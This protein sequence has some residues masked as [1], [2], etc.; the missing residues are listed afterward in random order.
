LKNIKISIA[1]GN[2][3]NNR[4]SL[5][6]W[7]VCLMT[8]V[9][10]TAFSLWQTPQAQAQLVT[11]GTGTSTLSTTVGAPVYWS[12][13]T[14]TFAFHRGGAI[15]TASEIN[16][17]GVFAGSSIDKL[18]WF[19]NTAGFAG[20][21]TIMSRVYIKEV[22]ATTQFPTTTITWAT[23]IAGATLVYDNATAISGGSGWKEFDISNYIWGGGNIM[24][25]V[26]NQ[27]PTFTGSGTIP[28]WRYTSTTNAA[29]ST[30]GSTMP[31]T[32]SR[33]S[34]RINVQMEFLPATPVDLAMVN[35]AAPINPVCNGANQ[36]VS[37]T[38]Q[39]LGTSTIDFSVNNATITCSVTGPNPTSFPAVVLNSGTLAS[40]ATQVITFSTNYDMT[41]AGTY[42][43]SFNVS[44]AGDGFAG[45]DLLASPI[46]T[47]IQVDA[48]ASPF[49]TICDGET[50]QLNTNI[51]GQTVGYNI[52]S[53]TP[54]VIPVPGG[55]LSPVT[56]DDVYSG[57]QTL[58]FTFT[59]YGVPQTVLYINSNGYVEFATNLATAVESRVPTLFPT[60][61]NP[62]N[63]I[64]FGW[65]DLNPTAGQ[66]TAYTVGTAPFRIYVVNFDNVN[67]FSATPGISTQLQLHENN[68]NSRFEIHLTNNTQGSNTTAL[69][70]ENA[71]GTVGGSPPGR[72]VG[73]WGAVTY[74]EAWRF[75]A[76]SPPTF[77]WSG[78]ALS[79]TNISNPTATPPIGFT[80]YTVTVT[81]GVTGCS[82]TD[83]VGINNL[84]A[85][86]P[87]P[88]APGDSLCQGETANLTASGPGTL[89]W[90]DAPVG[91]TQL[92]TGP[93]FNPTPLVTDTFYVD[94]FNGICPSVRTEVIVVVTP[95]PVLTVS[96]DTTLCSN[97]SLTLESQGFIDACGLV[98]ISE[99]QQFEAGTGQGPP[100]PF[101]PGDDWI[102]LTNI[103][104]VPVDISGWR[105]EVTGSA[106]G[107]QV[108]PAGNI[109]P[110]GAVFVIS[111]GAGSPNI[112]GVYFASTLPTTSSTVQNGYILYD[113]NNTIKDV[114]A[115]N[116]FNVVGTGAPAV[117]ASDW[118]GAIGT[119][120]SGVSR[121][122]ATDNNNASDWVVHAAGPNASSIG[123]LNT[124]F[125][126]P[127][128]NLSYSWSTGDTTQ[129]ITFIVSGTQTYTVTVTD[130]STG[131]TTTGSVTV[132]SP[133]VANNAPGVTNDTICVG[134]TASITATGSSTIK[135]YDSE[136][137]GTLLFT[138][139]TFNPTPVV[140][141]SYWAEDD[142]GVC[143][144]VRTE[145]VVVVNPLPTIFPTA[146][147]NTICEGSSTTLHA[148]NFISGTF[149]A[150]PVGTTN[151]SAAVG[152]EIQNNSAF[153]ITINYLYFNST[154]TLGTNLTESVYLRTSSM[155]CSYPTN[156]STDANWTLIASNIACVSGGTS[157]PPSVINYTL[158]P[159]DLNVTIPPGATYSFALGGQS[160]AYLTGS[161]CATNLGSDGTIT[162]Y[163]GWGG[164]L[165]SSI[166]N[167]NFYGK[168]DYSF[169]DPNLTFDWQPAASLNNNA[170]ADPV[171][172]PTTTT[173][174]TLTVT[175]LN[176]C[177][178]SD[179][180][181]VNVIPALPT[182]T[183]DSVTNVFCGCGQANIY[184][185]PVNGGNLEWY[186]APTGGNLIGTGSPLV[187][188]YACGTQTWYAQ[189]VDPGSGC[190]SLNR[191]AVTVIPGIA[192]DVNISAS[193]TQL[194]D[195]I[196]SA[197]LSASS[198]N[199]PNYQYSWAPAA[200]L[201][202]TSGTP[203][204]AT[205]SVTTTYILTGTD[206]STGC[207]NTDTVVINVGSTPIITSVTADQSVFCEN[208]VINLS[209]SA[210]LS[211]GTPPTN[212]FTGTYVPV[213]WTEQH[214]SGDLGTINFHTSSDLNMNSSDGGTGNTSIDVIH[215]INANGFVTFDWQYS[216][217]DG[218]NFDF[219]QYYLN[220][221]RTNVPGYNT[222][223]GLVQS[224]SASIAV[225]NGDVFGFT[226]T[227][228]DNLFGAATCNFNNVVFPG[229]PSGSGTI[230]YSWSPATNPA[231]GANVQATP[232]SG[233]TYYVVTAD[234]NGCTS[235][236]SILV[237]ALPTP[238]APACLGD[239]ICG[240][241]TVN[242][243]AVGSGG[244]LLWTDTI[245][246]P[247][248][249]TGNNYSPYVFSSG[250][251]YVVEDPG[252]TPAQIGYDPVSNPTAGVGY[253]PTTQQYMVFSVLSD[254]GLRINTVDI[255]P[256][257]PIGSPYAIQLQD[258]A[259]NNLG[260]L[261][262][263]VTTVT[264]TSV[265]PPFNVQTVNLNWFVP[266]GN[267]YRMRIVTSPNLLVH[268]NGTVAAGA[269][270]QIPFQILING[271][272]SH[273]PPAAPTIFGSTTFGLFYNW[274]V[275]YGCFSQAC[276]ANYQV[277]PAPPLS[278]TP[279]GSTSACDQANVVLTAGGDPS[280]TSFSWSPAAGLSATSG[281]SVTATPTVTTTYI[282][283]A[284]GG[285]CIDTASVTITVNPAPL[286]SI[287]IPLVD[288][289]CIGNGLQ[290][291]AVASKSSV[292]TIGGG[293]DPGLV[294]GQIFNGANLTQRSQIL[295]RASE[296]NAA[297]ILGPGQISSLAFN[298][299]NKLST[300]PYTGF[301]I[302]MAHASPNGCFAV[303]TYQTAGFT[304]VFT[305]NVSTVLGWNTMN[306]STP[307][308][309]DGVS[310]VVINTCFAN[311][312]TSFFDLVFM[313]ATPAC[314]T[315]RSDNADPC[316]DLTGALQ[317]FRPS[318][319]LT[320]GAVTYSWS[321]AANLDNPNIANPTFTATTLGTENFFVTVTDPASGCTASSNV[322]VVV[323]TFPEA[324]A[325]SFV[326]DSV[327]CYSGVTSF[328]STATLGMLQWQISND[329]INFSDISGADSSF[330][331]TDTL[332]SMTWYRLKAYCQDTVYS[333]ILK[334]DISAPQ[335]LSSLGDTICG[336][337]AVNLT[338]TSN[339]FP[340]VWYDEASG[341]TPLA[342]GSPFN[343]IITGTDTFYVAAIDTLISGSGNQAGS[344]AILI[345]EADLGGTDQI[346]IQNVS[347]SA[348]DVTGWRLAVSDS[349]TDI[350]FVNATVQVLSGTIA[351]GQT[352]FWTDGVT[353]PWGSNLFWNPGSFPS[354]T[355]WAI[356]MDNTGAIRDFVIWNWPSAN[357][358][359]MSINIPGNP[360]NPVAPASA[361][362]GNG[363]DATTANA[364]LSLSRNGTS[365]NNDLNDFAIQTTSI[366]A[367]NPGMTLPF[368]GS[369]GACESGRVMV[370]AV[371]TPADDITASAIDSDLCL[372]E[373]T[374]L[375][376][377]S[378]NTNYQYTWQP[379]NLIG[380][381]VNVCPTQTTTYIVY[382]IDPT[383]PDSCQSSD[384]IT[385][386]VNALPSVT[387][388]NAVPAVVCAGDSIQLSA[389][390]TSPFG[391]TYQVSSVPF[392]PIAGVGTAVTLGDDQTSAALPIGFN[393][394][395]YGNSYSQFV[396][397]SN[398]FISFDLAAPNGCCTGGLLPGAGTPNNIIT[399]PWEDFNPGAGG[400]IDYFTTGISPNQKLVVNF[401][402]IPHFG[403]GGSPMTS[404]IV[405][406]EGSNIIQVHITQMTTDGG[407]HTLGIENSNGTLAEVVPGRNANNSWSATN[408]G[409][410]F[411]PSGVTYSWAPAGLFSNPNQQTAN[412]VLNGP[413]TF[414][415]TVTD[416]ITGC[417]AQD[418]I[419]VSPVAVPQPIISPDDTTVC[420]GGSVTL[421]AS[422]PVNYPGGWPI[423]T[424][425]DWGFGPSP[426]STFTTVGVGLFQ[427]TVYFPPNF[428]GCIATS[429][430]ANVNFI[431]APVAVAI[432]TSALCAGDP[433]GSITGLA[434]LGVPPY[435]Y[436]WYDNNNVLIRDTI[437]FLGSDLI[438]GLP[439]GNYCLVVT[440]KANTNSYPPPQCSSFPA[441]AFVGEPLPVSATE[442]HVDVV[443][444]G[445]ASG[446]IDITPS[447]GTPPYTYL[448]S[449][450][451]TSEDLVNITAGTYTVTV[452]DANGCTYQT[453][454]DILSNP[455]I[456]VGK[457][458]V[459]VSCFGGGDGIA[460]VA[461][462]GGV[463]PYTYL[464]SNGATDEDADSLSSG[465][466][467]VTITDAVGCDTVVCFLIAEPAQMQVVATVVN[468]ACH[469]T[470]NGSISLA[471]SGG[472]PYS[473]GS[474][475]NFLWSNGA[476]TSS[477]SGLCAGTYTIT[478]SDS[479]GCLH[480]V[481]AQVIQPDSLLQLQATL[482]NP[483]CFGGSNG[484]IVAI[485]Q[486]GVAPYTYLWSN[487]QTTATATGL[488]A[489]TYVVTVTDA[490]GCVK[491][492]SY[493]L[494][495][496]PA[497]T[498]TMSVVNAS[499]NGAC[500]GKLIVNISGG[501]PPYSYLWNTNPA[502]T[503]N[504]ADNLCAGSY[505]LIVTDAN[506]CTY[507][508]NGTVTEPDAIALNEVVTDLV[509]NGANNGIIELYVTGG[510]APY[511][512]IWSNGNSTATNSGLSAGSY[513]VTV[514]D[515][516]GCVH[517]QTIIV[518]EPSAI[519]IAGT[520]T[521]VSCNGGT[522]GSISVVV[523]GGVS[524]YLFD[525]N[526]G[527]TTQSVAGLPAGVYTVTVT[528]DNGCSSSMS[529]TITEPTALSCI[530]P[531]SVTNV[532]CA[533]GSDG[534]ITAIPVGGTPPYS[535]LWSNGA[536]TSTVGGLSAGNYTVT[537]TDANGCIHISVVTVTEPSPL[538]VFTIPNDVSC[539]GLSD[540]S[541]QALA[542][543]GT[544]PYSYSWSTNPVQTTSTATGLAAGAYTVV[545][546]DANGCTQAV[547]TTINE[548]AEIVINIVRKKN[549][550]CYGGS[551]GIAK[552]KAVGGTSPFS[553]LWSTGATTQDIIGMPAGTYK[554]TVT[555]A[556]GCT[557]SRNVT[558]NSAPQMV[559][560]YIVTNVSCNGG[561][562]GSIDLTVTGGTPHNQN[563]P[564][565][566]TWSNGATTEDLTGISAGVYTVAVKDRKKCIIY[567][568]IIVNEPPALNCSSSST[569]ASCSGGNDGSASVFPTGG[570]V[571][572]SFLW[573]NGS[574]AITATNLAAGTYTVVVTDAK[575]CTSECAVTV[576]QS[577]SLSC[578]V[579]N[580][581][582]QPVSCFGANDGA[583][584]IDV[585]GG[586]GPYMYIWSTNPV[587][588]TA[589]ATGLPA[590]TYTVI[591]V[592]A[593]G[594][595]TSCTVVIPEPPA[596]NLSCS[597]DN[598]VSCN[599][600]NDGQA[601]AVA[602]GG[603]GQLS[604]LWNTNPAQTTATAVGLSTGVW[605][606]VV[607]DANG[608][609]AVCDVTVTEPV[610]ITATFS[611]V[612]T[613]CNGGNDG[614]ATVFP[615]GGTGA[616]TYLWSDGQTTQT[617]SGLVAGSYSV[618]VTDANNCSIVVS[619]II[620][621]QPNS[622]VIGALS[623]T[624]VSCT[625]GNNGTASVTTISGGTPP[626]TIL[627]NTVPPQNTATATGL[628]AGMYTVTV[629]DAVGCSAQDSI[630]VTEPDSAL[631]VT[632]INVVN[633]PCNGGLGSATALAEGGTAPYSYL[634][635]NGQT[636]ATAT[637]LTAGVYVVTV[638]D[639]NGCNE[640]ANVVI[641]QPGTL[642]V[643][644]DPSV[645]PSCFGGN[646]GSALAVPVG[647]T[648]PYSYLWSDG[649]TTDL[650][651]G[652]IAGVYTVTVTDAGG[653]TATE[654]V[655]I[656]DPSQIIA[657]C[658]VLDH[659]SCNGY[660]DGK[661][662]VSAVGGTGA[663]SYL[664]SNGATT[665]TANLVAAGVHTVTITDANGCSITC[666]VT[667]NE[668]AGMLLNISG[669]NV[670]CN[671]GN[672]G[673]A[674]VSVSGG[675]APYMFLWNN[676]QNTP[677]ATNLVAG[678]YTVIVQDFSG[679]TA[680][681][682][683][684]ITEPSALVCVDSTVV[685][686]T[687]FGSADGSGTT[688][689]SGGT[690]YS[691]GAPYTYAWNTVPVQTTAT[692]TGLAAG[693]Y[694]VTV[695]D[696]LGCSIVCC[697][698]IGQPTQLNY[699]YT[700]TNVDCNG[701]LT[702][703]I[704]LTVSG[705]VPSYS[706]VWSNGATTEDLSGVGA[707]T[708]SVT[709]SDV[710]GCVVNAS[711][712]VTEPA[713]LLLSTVGIDASCGQDN[714]SATVTATGGV[715]PYTY[716]WSDGQFYATAT[717]LA[718]GVYNVIV[719]DANGCVNADVVIIGQTGNLSCSIS[720]TTNV[721][722]NGYQDGSATVVVN[723]GTPP[724]SYNWNTAPFQSTATATGL[725]AGVY[726]VTITDA[727]GCSTSC[728]AVIN[729]PMPLALNINKVDNN[730]YGAATGH[731]TANV[732][733]GTQ[734]Y[735]Y[736][737]SNGQTTA[738]AGGL[739]A[740]TYFITVTDANG[741]SIN[742]SVQITE[743]A[744]FTC[745]T[746]C[747]FAY[748][749]QANGTA[750][751][752]VFG[753]Q[754]PYSYSWNT[755]PI[756]TNAI[757]TDLAA[758]TYTVVVTDANGCTTMCTVVV[759]QP[760]SL[761]AVLVPTHVSCNGAAD[762][763]LAVTNLSGGIMP[764]SFAWSNGQT[765]QNASGLAGG[766]YTVTITDSTGCTLELSGVVNEP[767]ALSLA[768]SKT[769]V[770]CNG[771][772]NG[773]A[774]VIVSGG[775]SPYSY[776]WS[777]GGNQN[778]ISN[779][780]AGWYYVT[781]SDANGCI[782]QDSIEVVEPAPMV[783]VDSILQ[784]A[785]CGVAN[786]SA[787]VSVSGGSGPYSY[788]W[789]TN[790]VQTTATATGLP[791]GANYVTVTDENG[792]V[793][794]HCVIM[795]N[796]GNLALNIASPVYAGGYN[797]RCNGGTD[798]SVNLT[799]V[800]GSGTYTYLWSNGATTEDITGLTAGTYT[801]T[802]DDGTCIAAAQITLTEP[803]AIAL[804]VT[805]TDISCFGGNN[806]NATVHVSGGVAPYSYNWSTAPIQT[807]QTATGLTA[808]IYTVT[809][810]D[811]NGC[812]ASMLVIISQP[813]TPLSIS[814][815][816][817]NVDCNGG[818][819]GTIDIVISGG[820]TPYSFV[821]DD[822]ATTEDRSDLVAGPY[823]INV[824][825]GKGCAAYLCVVITEPNQLVC[826][827]AENNISCN[828]ANDGTASVS[829]SGGTAP[830]SYAWSNGST[831][832][833]VSGLSG[834]TYTVI[835]T[836]ANGCSTQ[837][838]AS[839][840][841]PAALSISTS[842]TNVSFPGG[843]DGSATATV[844]GGTPPYSYSWNT[845]P[846]QTT[847]SASGLY[848][849]TYTVVV[850]DANNCTVAA[851]VVITEPAYSCIG[852][853]T[854]TTAGWNVAPN[855]SNAGTYLANNF[856]AVFPGPAY[857]TLGG[858]SYCAGGKSLQLTNV[859]AVKLFLPSTGS[860]ASLTANLVNPTFSTYSNTFA[861]E[862]VALTLNVKFDQYDPNFA[863]T[864]TVSLGNMIYAN[865]PFSGMTVNQILAEANKK[866]AGCSSPYSA[867]ALSN[868][869]ALINQSW[870]GGVQQNSVLTC[871]AAPPRVAHGLGDGMAVK[872]FPNP[873]DGSLSLQFNAE[874]G[875]QYT[876]HMMDM[877]GKMVYSHSG[878]ADG[879]LN[880]INYDF[881]TLRKGVYM[882]QLNVDG[883]SEIVRIV[884]Q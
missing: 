87:P 640:M 193:T 743:P 834:G 251:A 171:A 864:S 133:G 828:G 217:V 422:D 122:A 621:N 21:T 594:C 317:Q 541:I 488:T 55:A 108:I 725:G 406:S 870:S 305:G 573:S 117:T 407:N 159:V 672:S 715:G 45:N 297:G 325:I 19:Q 375:S 123:T 543:G 711:I 355:G 302:S 863:P 94:D 807:T 72:S 9:L 420:T 742:G 829:A 578:S 48:T 374:D 747:T 243:S 169:G 274:N 816:G 761:S 312:T 166:A 386:V 538:A 151:S 440:D 530:C 450:N 596:I 349:Y 237:T 306:F 260:G 431:D 226:M 134:E 624:S 219:P 692:A 787:Q 811:A 185:T 350:N 144:S 809:V 487:G 467:C 518:S 584:C 568:T 61:T 7:S 308:M 500:D 404:Q 142:N 597:V 780:L 73:N 706:F 581:C 823:T 612:N 774:G 609:T 311:A 806:G 547:T 723:G 225:S 782:A 721:T 733:G 521:N 299:S 218:A 152:F 717:G 307:F 554:V 658:S 250:S 318:M 214:T 626:Y 802:V 618:T 838:S 511:T 731:A 671:G 514:T 492:G 16:A 608:C 273:I 105:L 750:T 570:V 33:N 392:A 523:S 177:S 382:G 402:A 393:F 562:D 783:V 859:T 340:I 376:A 682:S 14:S 724:Y 158:I 496:P 416:N 516:S 156:V 294:T 564:Y 222:G 347:G 879:G 860:P 160:V 277:D 525:W 858:T 637:G 785:G 851:T 691:V 309:W 792:C 652:L 147:A 359:G 832:S 268:Q 756:Q 207:V 62:N 868:A 298:V 385:V 575:G 722:C 475:Y 549:V 622:I 444:Y 90:W 421:V 559:A 647:G 154:A 784:V 383:T 606:V 438:T 881:S 591:V 22:G 95:A 483:S 324:P 284:S 78:P 339:G 35:Q 636:T 786:G 63:C 426:D 441:C 39:Q 223:G 176:G 590:G 220:G 303:T 24:I 336:I 764:Y 599:G 527:E 337:G 162:M 241:G 8:A 397:A 362:T 65:E 107:N 507:Q 657:N 180:T 138:G 865:A 703:A 458:V 537:I 655:E 510:V 771:Y 172:S 25:L 694:Y 232:P 198:T 77:S 49:Y 878:I 199:D 728:I 796:N 607:T 593:N 664:W 820:T 75:D 111:R 126:Q 833:S 635:S 446:S 456:V 794:V 695:T 221:I 779:L 242:L 429:G 595:N 639:A 817:T 59:F 149:N 427:V 195:G 353:N 539:Y 824:I 17:Q 632:M 266:K 373:C 398:G 700:V 155:A 777:T 651:V 753:G 401:N 68:G 304:T 520:A 513:T 248:V 739:A 245:G 876:M 603:S 738:M 561:S 619:G 290:L 791:A 631:V 861:A 2:F 314:N 841:N 263:G 730:C 698:K 344:S 762:G 253:F 179:T 468:P 569:A 681:A 614:S 191:L 528:D 563:G 52:T 230:T 233:N 387:A 674:T 781:V 610:A 704:D 164:T 394:G 848:A 300:Q 867:T 710:N 267:Q 874:Y 74:P 582:F 264:N 788:A 231:T 27:R 415:V 46:N 153:P 660:S 462:S 131:C 118:S 852:F 727:S 808:G 461:V 354:F 368:A 533:G 181:I 856:N 552:V 121:I 197:T 411:A 40:L 435:R 495:N 196:G 254:N 504:V 175:D 292:V 405:L 381:T 556:N 70:S 146:D 757:A 168:V 620:V 772:S 770:S 629:T 853:R 718:A 583:A 390:G 641:S 5:K 862:L 814:G 76:A 793:T 465:I 551:D 425:F 93:T 186:D 289:V 804:S 560:L 437:S 773:S 493:S 453:A 758:G 98:V 798:G 586:T 414:V 313:T 769:D 548:P 866:L 430:I 173:I 460:S 486:G 283:T 675:T 684:V 418:S 106:V 342:Y 835:V 797:I 760:A 227:S 544:P 553:Y 648:Q 452:T 50:V 238:A 331:E 60:A 364:G 335:I 558:I 659:V 649:Q 99:V 296:L 167:R 627:W 690:P 239:T 315:F 124:T 295:I 92:A 831:M 211:G 361:W 341:G 745:N 234:N 740:G 367:T 113:Q 188:P 282:V 310:D 345:T 423:G 644:I 31:A 818:N 522:N 379:G 102:E 13:W 571:P 330:Y 29:G 132:T 630:E 473:S 683:I 319:R 524:P 114:V 696:S 26:E 165:T 843:S 749:G 67:Y 719:T 737:W 481:V 439:T 208:T 120:S 478:V 215:V 228:S 825:D 454:V 203:V 705:G 512:Y 116:G 288:T 790:P 83:T 135:W 323:S 587:Q 506:G 550:S 408:E 316:A 378:L 850:T 517:T 534:S 822:G 205:P 58:P 839:I 585:N 455:Q 566:Y 469:G 668:P 709:I 249:A 384:T 329:G 457:T 370:V 187:T 716:L 766:S 32:F 110:A 229:T 661:V 598:N 201:S 43:F 729:E 10:M 356:L 759:N 546:T 884:L 812:T 255:I 436:Q 678:V 389:S 12:A 212:G 673:S 190:S 720:S 206:T 540:G 270:Y 701:N 502:Q 565:R 855:G 646:D 726:T 363:I 491:L 184:A 377:N 697:V 216:T 275:S 326:G 80:T 396:I 735:T 328:T 470:C 645:N 580:Q 366:N 875:A 602:T 84:G 280:W 638:T 714:G 183:L 485:P 653:C 170:I 129:D 490:N 623:T 236:D 508:V 688:N 28:A 509:C 529:W 676:L 357:I 702:G 443:C 6:N 247:V 112:P 64:A 477:A 4:T 410:Q 748:C 163:S 265:N 466:Y 679:C 320:G 579:N 20:V 200:G 352:M 662:T 279:S 100:S 448:W 846:A 157:T 18:R 194:C 656:I 103:S 442:T 484:S 71:T 380:Q 499:C 482:T 810:G 472:T 143:P 321:P 708:Y 854:E 115:L 51:S 754:A 85:G 369:G 258:S 252:A 69:G 89:R 574:T 732:S 736:L 844:G 271:Y 244:T 600:G 531:S 445:D 680:S 15:Y 424:L 56:G 54:N 432:P 840:S 805:K 137:G 471:V 145:A 36:T 576:S 332:S 755:S 801:V 557:R 699:G 505:T 262:S 849:S 826:S 182:P 494:I 399:F 209:A 88:T 333:N 765:T 101:E 202:A 419:S 3:Y 104:P 503:T 235:Q 269:P 872:A 751:V 693:T 428:G 130:Q 127:P 97:N 815:T 476:T 140:T 23:E 775:T 617:A 409:W 346:E 526:T 412:A 615:V 213:S 433:S 57:P 34:N 148:N 372:G 257:G 871:P 141:T 628:V 734:P 119:S 417:T 663:L 535:Y 395:F 489:G 287:D 613:T 634:W 327:L 768:M 351:P 669:S 713:A 592:D 827:V 128:C 348:V 91:G 803:D 66:V 464:W 285:G 667:V 752:N 109:I 272:G 459:N 38:L 371:S 447:G 47:Q 800:S 873:T 82:A 746:S 293:Q 542:I 334:V 388:I 286:V 799:V 712:T 882:I 767:A 836:D 707:G 857:L 643:D 633:I 278:I 125:T 246:G 589:S 545:V 611:V 53:I 744:P 474:G 625:G 1:M 413:T 567:A 830:Y 519:V 96:D 555:D 687:C 778:V 322:V 451:A 150:T 842:Q 880:Q 501:T 161:G 869:V 449:N 666:Q 434:F 616:Y 572:Y 741:C 821:W 665:A 689:V 845:V 654:E 670:A 479:L 41:A 883:D 650:A 79:A 189:E 403:G 42:T 400:T 81:D 139:A 240:Q 210:I 192:D 480:Y 256:N 604:Y 601:T 30:G 577:S 642:Q 677:T 136:F 178:A 11:L 819:T 259:G 877:T 86:N 776:S 605:T 498:H 44:I 174:Y 37:A 301:T 261:V 204:I 763:S 536:Q 795:P 789:N 338:A 532:S 497:F 291:N 588:T 686:P 685:A 837:C 343:P 276:I 281:A 358:A 224:S 515:A 813:A 847:A 365:D 360:S 463:G 391:T